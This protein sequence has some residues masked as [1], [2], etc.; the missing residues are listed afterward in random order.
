MLPEPSLCLAGCSG[1]CQ[2]APR[3]LGAE[4]V[5]GQPWGCPS[6]PAHP[7]LAGES[8]PRV[9]PAGL[10]GLSRHLLTGERIFWTKPRKLFLFLFPGF[11][12]CGVTLSLCEVSSPRCSPRRTPLLWFG[13]LVPPLPKSRCTDTSMLL[14]LPR[15]LMC[16]AGAASASLQRCFSGLPL[17]C[18]L[19]RAKSV[20]C[21]LCQVN[22]FHPCGVFAVGVAVMGLWRARDEL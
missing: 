1:C 12:F 7:A 21:W 10:A 2:G 22:Y 20:Q 8:E 11:W 18:S 4:L 5:A 9:G 3:V 14:P 13:C 15:L 6:V 19:L 17:L 16:P